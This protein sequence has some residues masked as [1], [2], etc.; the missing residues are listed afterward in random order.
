MRGTHPY[1]PLNPLNTQHGHSHSHSRN[2]SLSSNLKR[3]SGALFAIFPYPSSKVYG[4]HETPPTSAISSR[5]LLDG[6]ETHETHTTNGNGAHAVTVPV[7]A[8]MTFRRGRGQ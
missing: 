8:V 6:D 5:G 2:G 4:A 7:A 3:W 1:T